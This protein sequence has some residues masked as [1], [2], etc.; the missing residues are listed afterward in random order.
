MKTREYYQDF[1]SRIEKKLEFIPP[2]DIE[3]INMLK[4][5]RKELK[6]DLLKNDISN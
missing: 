2:S 4:Q 6:K 1:I 3:R 5:L